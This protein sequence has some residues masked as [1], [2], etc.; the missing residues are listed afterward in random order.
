MLRFP[1][2]VLACCLGL[3]CLGVSRPAW[4]AGMTDNTLIGLADLIVVGT[5]AGNT[6]A[7]NQRQVTMNVDRVLKGQPVAQVTFLYRPHPSLELAADM[8]VANHNAVT[9]PLAGQ[10][11]VFLQHTQGGWAEVAGSDSVQPAER[12]DTIAALVKSFPLQAYFQ[13]SSTWLYFDRAYHVGGSIKNVGRLPYVVRSCRLEGYYLSPKIGQTMTIT[14]DPHPMWNAHAE[15]TTLEP[16][17]EQSFQQSVIAQMPPTMNGIDPE[18]LF[19]TPVAVRAVVELNEVSVKN[20]TTNMVATVATPWMSTLVGFSPKPTERFATS[21]AVATNEAEFQAVGNE[22]WPLPTTAGG[23]T[24]VFIGLRVT[25]HGDKPVAIDTADTVQ[26]TIQDGTGHALLMDMERKRTF[27]SHPIMLPPG[28]TRSISRN[29][30]ITMLPQG[31]GWIMTGP[32]GAGGMWS[33]TLAQPGAY[34]VSFVYDNTDNPAGQL[35]ATGV[36]FWH[37]KATVPPMSVRA[38]LQ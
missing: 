33:V 12:A 18:T 37:G 13:A 30:A 22:A 29:G 38:V 3:A 20:D 32:D 11:L 8:P 28:V 6:P 16:G 21:A 35:D 36:P 24:S 5:V 7:E 26:M 17:Q 19:M 2:W 14:I 15:V 10:W 34:T 1:R 9:V 31:K 23:E 4:S 27:A 25:N